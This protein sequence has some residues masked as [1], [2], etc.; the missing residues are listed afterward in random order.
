MKPFTAET[1]FTATPT[2]AKSTI[3][4]TKRLDW[5]ERNLIHLHNNRSTC[6]VNM[7]GRCVYGQLVNE[8]RGAN[9][10]PSKFTV[11]HRSIRE[12]IDEAMKTT[13]NTKDWPED[14]ALENGNYE[15]QCICCVGKFTGLKGRY[16][17]KTCAN[18]PGPTV[19][20]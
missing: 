5:L 14:F 7:D 6:S 9:A 11:N 3:T 20:S 16:L 1:T 10:G 13:H 12:A 18:T 15:C 2:V 8:A 4:D 19:I 17:C